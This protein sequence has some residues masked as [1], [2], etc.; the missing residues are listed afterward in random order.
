MVIPSNS[1]VRVYTAVRSARGSVAVGSSDCGRWLDDLHAERAGAVCCECTLLTHYS[2]QC[3]PDADT[4]HCVR[5]YRRHYKDMLHGTAQPGSFA[6]DHPSY[7]KRYCSRLPVPAPARLPTCAFSTRSIIYVDSRPAV[8]TTVVF[9]LLLF[10]RHHSALYK[11]VLRHR[12]FCTPISRTCNLKPSVII[13]S[14]R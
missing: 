14:T 8:F 2:V 10:L 5:P 3:V 12:W 4:L 9:R 7:V 1:I 6:A 11:A 13:I